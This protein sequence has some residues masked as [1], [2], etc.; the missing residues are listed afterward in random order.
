MHVGLPPI[1]RPADLM[2]EERVLDLRESPKL[3]NII[4]EV[5]AARI[6][7]VGERHDSYA[8]HLKQLEII[9]KI[10]AIHPDLAIGMEQFQHPFQSVLDHYIAGELSEPELLL[11][12]EWYDRWR[13]DYRLYRPI[14]SFARERNIP[15]VALNVAKEITAK[16]SQGGMESLSEEERGQIPATIDPPEKEYR[17]WLYETYKQHPHADEQQFERFLQVQLLWDEGMAMAVTEHLQ[18]H[19][20]RKMIVLVGSGH[21]MFG[22]GI[23]DRASRRLPDR[24]V[25]L[26][27]QEAVPAEPGIADFLLFSGDEQLPPAGLMGI[28]LVDSKH[29]VVAKEVVPDSAAAESG[30][31]RDDLIVAIDGHNVSTSSEVRVLLLDRKPGDRIQLS[32]QRKKLMLLKKELLLDLMLKEPEKK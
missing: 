16:V 10:H 18:R 15:V 7:Y 26:L 19:P 9:R 5:A 6:I 4:D 13:F 11:K 23:P 3:D 29:G 17:D 28:M 12:S 20:G 22:A 31:E 8:D 25:I 1:Y 32:I 14:L 24:R 21:L 2:L 27:P 30:V